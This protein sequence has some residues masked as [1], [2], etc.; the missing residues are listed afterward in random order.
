MFNNRGKNTCKC[1]MNSLSN[2]KTLKICLVSVKDW[3]VIAHTEGLQYKTM[4]SLA[5]LKIYY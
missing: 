2:T 1:I 3:N 5:R 4:M